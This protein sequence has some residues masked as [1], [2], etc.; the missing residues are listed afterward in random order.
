[1]EDRSTTDFSLFHEQPSWKN[2]KQPYLHNDA[3]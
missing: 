2:F 1:M 3:R